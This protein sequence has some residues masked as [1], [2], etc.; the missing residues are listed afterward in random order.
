MF[1]GQVTAIRTV[2]GDGL[3]LFAQRLGQG[4]GFLGIDA[5]GLAHVHLQVEQRERQGCWGLL[6]LHSGIGHVCGLHSARVS[7]LNSV[8]HVDDPVLVIERGISGNDEAGLRTTATK[9]QACRN[10]VVKRAG[11]TLVGQ[12]AVHD[13]PQDRGLH[14]AY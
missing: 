6:F 14:A 1:V 8:C 3:V 12:V 13:Q 4:Q 9:G 2:V 7:H 10:R 11:M 5:V